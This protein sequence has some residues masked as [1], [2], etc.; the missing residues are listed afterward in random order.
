MKR[1]YSS[2]TRPWRKAGKPLRTEARPPRGSV[3]VTVLLLMVVFT[4]LG[5][6]ML[7]ASG[8]HMKI[9]AYRK[10]S[11]LLDCASESGLKRGLQELMGWLERTG[12]LA[13]VTDESLDGLRSDP[14]RGFALLLE[15]ALGPAFPRTLEESFD[16]MAWES[17]ADCGFG[18]LE[19]RGGYFRIAAA[20]RIESSGG[21]LGMRPRRISVLEG[22][23][24]LLAGRLPLPAIPL[25]IR[26]EVPE[27][28]KAAFL[29]DN[30]I[31]LLSRPG[32]LVGP[33]L[34]ASAGGVIPGDPGAL[35]AKA[36]S[37]GV[38]RPGDLSPGA[39]RLALGL[40][41]ST[42][43]VPEGVYLIENDLGLGGVFVEGDVDEMILAL[44][45][46]TQV[47][48]FRTGGEEW[49]LEFSPARCC[50]EFLTPEE[51]FAYDL[52]PLPIILVNGGIGALGGGAA[53]PDGRVEMCFDGRTPAVLDGVGLTIV[54][55]DKITIASHLVLE[56][57]RWQDG[58]PYAKGAEAQL[59]I[60]A[61]GQDLVSGAAVEG[62]IDVADG[63]PADLKLQAS[64]TAAAGGFR[65]G[66]DGKSVELLGALHADSFDGNGN[67]LALFRDERAADGR[68]AAGSPLS[69]T[70]QL[71][72]GPLKVLSWK[73]Y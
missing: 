2:R 41:P 67:A 65:I 45:G 12:P 39:L 23:L 35:V 73:E 36:I 50:T 20:L 64:L 9:N 66:G 33:A 6:A 3:T 11:L 15:D 49:R 46:D 68:F 5:L 57:V 70:P 54:S 13:P 4:G 48:V 61:A 10:V 19:D 26:K 34:A 52:L 27:A 44:R 25:Y 47:I 30:G 42:E 53:G 40:E 28:E 14:V 51:A 69:A 55:A 17:R 16:G 7:H 71:A 60:Y 72:L 62:G 43:A 24:G 22:S 18:G 8:V 59:V 21:L 38:F 32:E 58:I 37:I 1:P 29:E 63:A 31:S 56:G